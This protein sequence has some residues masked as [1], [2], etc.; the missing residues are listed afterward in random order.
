M[1]WEGTGWL[2][3]P[4]KTFDLSAVAPRHGYNGPLLNRLVTG[5]PPEQSRAANCPSRGWCAQSTQRR[6][7]GQALRVSNALVAYEPAT[8]KKDIAQATLALGARHSRARPTRPLSRPK[9]RLAR[10]SSC[11]HQVHTP[12]IDSNVAWTHLV[13]P[14]ARQK[15]HL[16]LKSNQQ[17]EKVK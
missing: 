17:W 13:R 1:R 2:R 8:S 14:S 15:L 4:G 5:E 7:D 10:R 16:S 3:L 9:R 12:S 6:P 11:S